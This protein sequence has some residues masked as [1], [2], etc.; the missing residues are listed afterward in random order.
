MGDCSDDVMPFSLARPW[1]NRNKDNDNV[2]QE[3]VNSFCL[4]NSWHFA[5]ISLISGG[6]HAFCLGNGK[7]FKRGTRLEP[8]ATD[9]PQLP[10]SGRMRPS[11]PGLPGLGGLQCFPTPSSN[12]PFLGGHRLGVL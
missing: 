6:G 7:D 2:L 5:D 10:Q 3:L 8:K 1:L 12:P 9:G 11:V 4:N